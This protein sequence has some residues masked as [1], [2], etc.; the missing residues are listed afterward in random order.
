[1]LLL[2]ADRPAALRG[3]GAN[4]T[5]DQV[6]IFGGY[7]RAHRDLPPPSDRRP[8]GEV[9]GW[10]AAAV[11]RAGGEG[12]RPPGPV[13]LNCQFEEP[14]A[15]A[16]AP[17]DPAC[18]EGLQEWEASGRPFRPAAAPA[19]PGGSSA[20]AAGG[21]A[22]AAA[23]AAVAGAQRGLLVLGEQVTPEEVHA[24]VQLAQA[25]GWPVAADALSGLRAGA[26]AAAGPPLALLPHW[27]HMLLLDREH[28]HALRPDV[29]LQVGG[30]LTSK[31]T[32]Q[33][34]E[35]CAA[36][37]RPQATW[38]FAARCP[39][40]FDQGPLVTH[41]LFCDALPALVAAQALA[42]GAQAPQLRYTALLVALEAEVSAAVHAA[43][44]AMPEL[45][46]PEVAR[47]VTQELPPGE[48]LFVGNSMPV[49]DVDMFCRPAAAAAGAAAAQGAVPSGVGAPVAA[50]RGASGI[51]GV[52]STAAGFAEGL[53]RGCTLLVGDISFLHDING[54]N[55]L[56]SGERSL[57]LSLSRRAPL[58]CWWFFL[59][60]A[61]RT[62]CSPPWRSWRFVSV[63][64][65]PAPC[66]RRRDALPADHGAG[67]QR[68]RRH[69]LLPP[70]R[71]GAARGGVHPA[72]GHP[73]ARRP[74]GCASKP[75]PPPSLPASLPPSP[76][77]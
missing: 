49:R 31:R 17:W 6:G 57:S 36:P 70:G 59:F 13:H 45:C 46:E 34:L 4:Q 42:G 60:A 35:W 41:R 37:P 19:P 1:M 8:A 21:A 25:L 7:V 52:L 48:G 40:P 55:L 14:L 54:L 76:C 30:H 67:Q 27:D 61:K 20:P 24:A 65:P 50:N 39:G 74:A 75:R 51:D 29:V 38:L 5:I 69:L 18:L 28:W 23:F 3:T 66:R 56:R 72:V 32:A 71:R 73:A 26:H 10:V 68:R 9:L 11:E 16:P 47:V 43:L 2:T 62:Q 15:P 53:G 64:T 44:D 22:E 12:R 63:L 58:A 33:F 77:P